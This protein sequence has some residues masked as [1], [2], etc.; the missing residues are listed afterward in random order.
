MKKQASAKVVYTTRGN[1]KSVLKE[2]DLHLKN[3]L[4]ALK[5]TNT[6]KNQSSA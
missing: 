1:T 3:Y 4:S 5:A 6:S 2:L